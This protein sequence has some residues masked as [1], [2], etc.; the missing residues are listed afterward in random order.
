MVTELSR[1]AIYE[2]AHT[3]INQDEWNKRNNEYLERHKKATERVIELEDL[4]LERQNKKR[5]IGKIIT[6][7]EVSSSTI[8][9]FDE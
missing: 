7:L 9:K 6:E 4:K 1:K 2:N 8:D 5:A 3:E